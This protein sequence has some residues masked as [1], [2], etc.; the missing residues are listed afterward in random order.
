MSKYIKYAFFIIISLIL[1]CSSN[2]TFIDTGNIIYI[3]RIDSLQIISGKESELIKFPDRDSSW[4]WCP[5]PLNQKDSFIIYE[6]YGLQDT[7]N[8]ILG[9]L[10]LLDDQ[11]NVLDTIYRPKPYE[12]I[13]TYFPS[14]NDS[15]VLI[16][17]CMTDTNDFSTLQLSKSRIYLF[18]FSSKTCE[19]L[20]LAD[21]ITTIEINQSPWSPGCNSFVFTSMGNTYNQENRRVLIHNIPKSSTT[22]IDKGSQ[23]IW[24]SIKD[25]YL[26]FIRGCSLI[27]YEIL[28]KNEK[29]I[30]ETSENHKIDW[31]RFSSNKEYIIV[32][33]HIEKQINDIS[34]DCR[35]TYT[36][37]I[38]LDD[39]K[40]KKVNYHFWDGN[41]WKQ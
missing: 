34:M 23:A 9:Q 1:S 16:H 24:H 11:C 2:L 5:V 8:H 12:S 20:V 19:R 27:Q 30:Y 6:S 7:I 33:N 37:A 4:L 31:F 14:F 39:N 29:V 41:Y 3:G 25:D 26:L 38:H 13:Q 17:V 28:S 40:I 15:L 36:A 18:N 32:Q 10:I 35:A 21:S 22:F